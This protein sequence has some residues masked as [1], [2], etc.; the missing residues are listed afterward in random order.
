M[1][2]LLFDPDVTR[3]AGLSYAPEHGARGELDVYVPRA[4]ATAAPV[5]YQI[6][7]G[8]WMIGDKQQQGLPLML[9]AARAGWVCVMRRST[10]LRSGS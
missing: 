6:H 10:P 2:F 5:L 4:G 9:Q 1:P 7:G 8:A 3:V